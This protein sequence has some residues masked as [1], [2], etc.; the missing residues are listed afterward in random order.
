MSYY[1]SPD[2]VA[3][4]YDHRIVLRELRCWALEESAARQHFILNLCQ[5][6][7]CRLTD[8]FQELLALL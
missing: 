7:G 2:I 6:L 3:P 8:D 4:N 1:R 5:L